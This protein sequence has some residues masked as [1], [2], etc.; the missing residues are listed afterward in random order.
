MAAEGFAGPGEVS[1]WQAALA[2]QEDKLDA[3]IMSTNAQF[4]TLE[5]HADR[6]TTLLH[7]MMA[8]MMRAQAA[9]EGDNKDEDDEDDLEGD[10]DED[11]DGI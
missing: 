7:K 1:S 8:M 2:Q 10:Y 6:N 5:G 9:A 11:E 3:F 4:K